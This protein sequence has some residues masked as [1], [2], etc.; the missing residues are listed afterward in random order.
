M[1]R[2]ENGNDSHA[3]PP[4]PKG[5]NTW[6][7]YAVFDMDTRSAW[8]EFLF[9]SDPDLIKFN[10]EDIQKAVERELR[11]LRAKAGVPDTYPYKDL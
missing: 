4:P 11:M 9:T 2:E 6:L 1:S 5:F 8:H 10:R 3:L 7:D